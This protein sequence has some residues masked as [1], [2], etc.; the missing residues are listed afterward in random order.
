MSTDVTPTVRKL[1]AQVAEEVRSV[2]GR[3]DISKA[4]LA[5]RLGVSEMWTSRRLRGQLPIDLDDMERIAAALDVTVMDLLPRDV[6]SQVTV[7]QRELASR[8]EIRTRPPG[9]PSGSTRP[10][11]ARRPQRRTPRPVTGY[12]LAV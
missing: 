8:N 10:T 1:S 7:T 2:M 5:R 9:H 12:G 3:K 6:R 11:G 4:E